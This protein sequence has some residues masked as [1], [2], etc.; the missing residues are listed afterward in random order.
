MDMATYRNR[1]FMAGR[2]SHLIQHWL[3]IGRRLHRNGHVALHM[4]C[5]DRASLMMDQAWRYIDQ[6]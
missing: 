2:R 4:R 5:I 1:L 3:T 6:R